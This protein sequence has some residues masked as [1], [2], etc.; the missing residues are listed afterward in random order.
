MTSL[1]RLC[2]STTTSI[3]RSIP[4]DWLVDA[5]QESFAIDIAQEMRG[6]SHIDLLECARCRLQFF[7][8]D[9]VVGSAQLYA[10]LEKF[11]WYYMPRKWEHDVALD[12]L[13][14]CQTLLEIGCGF[15]D[16]VVRARETGIQAEGIDLNESAVR[17]AQQRGLPVQQLDLREAVDRYP[18]RFDAV[19]SFQVLEHVS[20]PGDFLQRSCALI[21][22]GGQLL[23]GVPNADSFLKHQFN[24]LDMPP[25]HMTR[26][27]IRTMEYLCSLFPLRLEHVRCEPLA[28][29]HLDSYV[30]VQC[31]KLFGKRWLYRVCAGLIAPGLKTVLKRTNLHK[32]LIGQTLYVSFVR[33]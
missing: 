21:R 27:P 29:Y 26:W 4:I 11:D 18:L 17:T 20:N 22:P 8:P 19:C 9:R 10:Q 13:Q 12:D 1:C 23:L 30:D 5:W 25:H 6:V 24:L 16:F 32:R 31:A 28:V 15:G 2:G 33:I 3:I 14:G 7:M